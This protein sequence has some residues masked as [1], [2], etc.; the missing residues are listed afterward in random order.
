VSKTTL[1]TDPDVIIQ[2]DFKRPNDAPD[3]DGNYSGTPA[4]VVSAV[5]GDLQPVVGDVMLTM[6]GLNPRATHVF[7]TETRI[8]AGVLANDYADKDGGP[9][10]GG[11]RFRVV[12]V[13][14]FGGTLPQE[15]QLEQLN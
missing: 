12:E 2:L 4:T 11:L 7:F 5:R 1:V 8:T 9:D 10:S 13:R 3:A 15:I 6:T 14:D